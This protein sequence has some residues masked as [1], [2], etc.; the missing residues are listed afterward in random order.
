M[1][2]LELWA[3]G[4]YELA[5]GARWVDGRLVF[6]DILTGRLLELHDREPRQLA[7]LDV[8]LGAAA[9]VADSPG[10]W[11]VAAGTGFALLHSSG[12]LTW[13]DR[14]EDGAAVPMRMNDGACDPA[15][16]FWAGSMAYDGTRGAGSLYRVETDGTVTCVLDGMTI[17]N[18]P[19]FSADGT[20]MYVT[21]TVAGVIFRCTVGPDGRVTGQE[22]FV[23]V[24]PNAGSPDGMTVDDAGRVWVA[25]WD[26]SAVHCYESDGSLYRVVPVPA[27]RPTSVCLGGPAGDQLFVTT[28]RHGLDGAPPESGAVLCG[29]VG[30]RAV[31]PACAFGRRAEPA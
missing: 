4:G 2:G 15:G 23:V 19:A 13:L 26:G 1:S 14:P 25:L 29:R 3:A 16:R 20:L 24:P 31:G 30:V 9:P 17:V 6:V 10:D 7:A 5:E 11:I 12:G 18:G 22:P 27:R 21:D 28:A 8:P